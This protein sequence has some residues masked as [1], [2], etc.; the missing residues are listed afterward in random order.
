[1]IRVHL[2]TVAEVF[3]TFQRVQ[4]ICGA[5][6]AYCP[7]GTRILICRSKGNGVELTTDHHLVHKLRGTACQPPLMLVFVTVH[8]AIFLFS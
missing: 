6:W 2:L 1:M 5:Y 8:S 7:V 4:T 3:S